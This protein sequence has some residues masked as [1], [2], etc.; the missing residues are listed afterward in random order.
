MN[1]PTHAVEQAATRGGLP[2]SP[3]LGPTLESAHLKPHPPLVDSRVVIISGLS[4]LLAFAAAVIAWLLVSLISLIT[5]ISFYARFSTQAAAPTLEHW[6]AWVIVVPVIGGLIVGFMARYGSAGIRGHGIPEAME[7]VLTRQSRIPPR[8]TFLKPLSAAIA[9]GTGGP[10]GAEGPIIA[11]G[12]ALGSLV[13]QLLKSTA[14][15]RKTLLAAG[16]AAGMAA[17]F[18]SPVAAT[19]LAIELLLFEFR[20]RSFVPV[21]LAST[22]AAGVRFLFKL[23]Y[24]VFDMPDIHHL[25][26]F[27][28]LIYI[29]IGALI[30]LVSVFVTRAVYAVEDLFDLLPIH[31]MWWPAIGAVVVG[32]VGYFAPN[33]LGVGYDN[34]SHAI[35]LSL[36]VKAMAILCILK[37]TSW[38]I[39]LGSGTSGGTLA[40]LFTI[41]STLG[42]LMGIGAAHLF[43]HADI[44]PR[45]AALVGMAALFAG[46]SRALLTSVV[47]AFETTLRPLGLLPLLGGCTAAY[48]VSAALMPDTIMTAKIARRGIRVP[49]EY[50][51]DFL[52]QLTVGDV[53]TVNPISLKS[54]QRLGEVRSWMNSGATGSSHQG[55][56]VVG[57][58]GQLVGVLTRRDLLSDNRSAD[59]DLAKLIHRPPLTIFR[60]S[61]LRQAADHMVGADVGRLAVIDRNEDSKLIGIITRGDVLSAHRRRLTEGTKAERSLRVSRFGLRANLKREVRPTTH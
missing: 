27:S 56:P 6:G 40:P 23:P 3:S 46:A 22:T 24:P 28:L 25:P 2:V 50:F 1:P 9:I 19:L 45:I 36:T 42:A 14:A 18:G 35:S 11:T 16:A 53:F 5:N 44:D 32:V 39:A 33:T 60:D 7:Q 47:F 54:S 8:L 57:E 26:E 48:F 20:P 59:T 30:G 15:E 29:L 17:T 49:S 41:G 61:T 34:I 58:T 37:F 31:W 43:P 4:I 13:G 10:F 55:Y 21:A 51:A 52:D 38:C 12:G